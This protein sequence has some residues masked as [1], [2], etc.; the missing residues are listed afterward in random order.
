MP[1]HLNI[2]KR[3]LSKPYGYFQHYLFVPERLD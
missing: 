2:T 1:L 3:R